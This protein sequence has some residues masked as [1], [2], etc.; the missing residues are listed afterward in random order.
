LYLGQ[1]QGFVFLLYDEFG[2]VL[3]V[4]QDDV[5]TP[6]KI[7]SGKKSVSK[8]CFFNLAMANFLECKVTTKEVKV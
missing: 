3:D 5:T 7:I 2:A 6:P 8:C 1:S 4:V